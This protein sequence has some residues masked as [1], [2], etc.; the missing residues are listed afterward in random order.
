[1]P[2][3]STP[4]TDTKVKNLKEKKDGRTK[5]S[6][7]WLES[8]ALY[9]ITYDISGKVAYNKIQDNRGNTYYSPYYGTFENDVFIMISYGLKKRQFMKLE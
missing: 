7:G 2:R 9:D 8:T 1:M 4:L 5:V 6:K 3:I